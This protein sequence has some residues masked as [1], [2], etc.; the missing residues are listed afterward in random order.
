MNTSVFVV[1]AVLVVV[2]L[3]AWRRG[4]YLVGCGFGAA[5][6]LPGWALIRT[7][8]PTLLALLGLVLAALVW[9]RYG[10]TMATVT[11]WGA[12]SRRKAGVA[13]STDIARLGSA[14]AMRRRTRTFAPPSPRPAG[15][16]GR[17]S[18]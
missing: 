13:S 4:A 5:A 7:T 12:S 9:H 14:V 11:R 16:S 3:V 10:R 18:Y 15:G 8:H 17:C 1:F 2:M 6:V